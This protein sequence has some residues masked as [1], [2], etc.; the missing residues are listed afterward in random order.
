MA[1]NWTE[2]RVVVSGIGVVSPLGKDIDSLWA[3][4][5]ASKCGIDKIT[6]FDASEYD[7][8]IAGEIRDFNPAP[9][10]PSPKEARR[11]DRFAQVGIFAAHQAL[12]NSGIDLEK[13]N[14][15]EIGV[16]IALEQVEVH[17]SAT[18]VR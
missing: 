9:A 15:D 18:S 13:V 2:R 11:T 17:R 4:L 3:N 14:R 6:H 5:I 16:I 12:L 10:F 1:N 7:T 8:Q